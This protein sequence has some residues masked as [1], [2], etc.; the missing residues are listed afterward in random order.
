MRGKRAAKV[1]GVLGAG[2]LMWAGGWMP[3]VKT[4]APPAVAWAAERPGG[5]AYTPA[6][7]SPERRAIMDALRGVMEESTGLKLIFVVRH[8]KVKG[9]WAWLE[10][11]PQSPDGQKRYEPV[12]ALLKWD[13]DSWEVA[14]LFHAE[15]DSPIWQPGFARSLQARYPGV[16]LEIFPPSRR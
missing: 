13:L 6:P 12:C 2:M 7:G 5:P 3:E 11:E 8:L 14:Q 1:A 4:G 9:N 15:E 16:P 10:V